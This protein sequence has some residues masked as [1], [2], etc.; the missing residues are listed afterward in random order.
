MSPPPRPAELAALHAELTERLAVPGATWLAA[1]LAAAGTGDGGGPGDGPGNGAT[2]PWEAAFAVAARRVGRAPLPRAGLPAA[3]AARVLL[4]HAAGPAA[5]AA[6]V[7]RLYQQGDAAERRAVLHALPHLPGLGDRA[8]PLVEDALRAND[9]RLVAAAVGGYAARHLDQHQWRHAVLKCVFT[10]V[11]L[12]TVT[13]LADRADAELLRMLADYA[14]ER[15][16]AGRPVPADVRHLL[17]RPPHPRV[18]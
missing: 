8:L 18:P 14:A 1:A 16:A 3:D 10:G 2:P 7:T 4:L 6:T 15:E 9:T 13:A 12:A 11:P 17:A 5:D